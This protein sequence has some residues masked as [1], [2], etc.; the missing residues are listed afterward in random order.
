MALVST[1]L[2]DR[3]TAQQNIP[4]ALAY[5]RHLVA[6]NVILRDDDTTLDITTLFVAL[7][8]GEWDN[9]EELRLNGLVLDSSKFHFHPGKDG[10]VGTGGVPGDQKID[11]WLPT[12]IQGLT[13]SRTAYVVI[14]SDADIEAPTSD[15]FV[16]GKYRTRKVRTYDANGVE[17]GFRYS[18]NPVWHVLDLLRLRDPTTRINFAMFAAEA[19]VCDELI[20]VDSGAN[21]GL[22]GRVYRRVRTGRRGAH[23]RGRHCRVCVGGTRG[24]GDACGSAVGSGGSIPRNVLEGL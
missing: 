17:T 15:F 8:E 2:L 6:G 23:D 10:E 3:L 1:E 16:L 18:A 13:F 11:L 19:V 14:R 4:L 21:V 7:G 20:T 12:G 5:G 24:S 22:R 9:V